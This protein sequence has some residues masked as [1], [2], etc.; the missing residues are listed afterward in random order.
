L[1]KIQLQSFL[2][3]NKKY[4]ISLTAPL[5]NF[6]EE[7]ELKH[8]LLKLKQGDEPAFNTLYLGYSKAL[9]Q[10]INRIVKDDSVSDEL[11]QDLFLKI[12]EKRDT[13]NLDQ[14]FT[15][16]IYTVANNLIYDYLRKVSKEKRLHAR[17]LIHAVDY[18]LHTEELLIEKETTKM[19]QAAIE[20]LSESRRNVFQLCKMEGKTYQETA[21]ILG[22]T[23]ATVNSH[24]VK[25]I[26]SIKAYLYKHQEIGLLIII[27][28]IMGHKP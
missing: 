25:S 10:K 28:A 12:W 24:M 5:M 27:S 6:L 19:I 26:K 14:S 7:V 20:Q 4:C 15:A 1:I 17:L 13:I 22:I 2:L 16:F 23:V 9:Y 21:E 3:N 11:L 8:L 18:Y